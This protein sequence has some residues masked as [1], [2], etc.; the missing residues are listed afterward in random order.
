[1]ERMES[2]YN[3]SASLLLDT[4]RETK[5]TVRSVMVVAHNPG[6]HELA[7]TLAGADRNFADTT[8]RRLSE[9]YPSGALTEFTVA[10]PWHTLA[11]GGGRLVRFL[12]PRDLPSLAGTG[13]G[14]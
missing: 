11:A 13:T 5:E 3:A 9:G 2:L 12:C 1:M 8:L 7:I 14:N 4:V 6:I 10:G